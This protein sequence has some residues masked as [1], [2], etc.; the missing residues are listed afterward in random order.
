ML[1]Q[2]AP[3]PVEIHRLME[4]PP[5][6]ERLIAESERE[7]FRF[8]RRLADDWAAGRNRFAGP[9]EGLWGAAVAGQWIGTCGLNIEDASADGPMG[10]LRRLYVCAD[11]RRTG[12]GSL[13]VQT[14]LAAAATQFRVVQLRTDN[15][16]AAAFYQALGFQTVSGDPNVTHRRIRA[17][18]T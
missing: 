16:D 5:A 14:A 1:D 3:P 10:R 12:V 13:L 15:P 2:D 4:L 6:L 17:D 7:R 11:W 18:A 9:G 8:L